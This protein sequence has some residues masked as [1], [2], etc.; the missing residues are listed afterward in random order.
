[1]SAIRKQCGKDCEFGESCYIL[2]AAFSFHAV[3]AEAPTVLKPADLPQNLASIGAVEAT[4]D[5]SAVSDSE[6]LIARGWWLRTDLTTMD[7]CIIYL[8]DL[9][10]NQVTPYDVC[11]IM[12]CRERYLSYHNVGRLRF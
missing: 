2:F 6:E 12:H 9:V 1:M 10:V 5:V 8:R 4:T 7:K 11:D 3:F